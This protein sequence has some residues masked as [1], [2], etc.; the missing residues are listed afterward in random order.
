MNLHVLHFKE[1][2]IK[3]KEGREDDD[4]VSSQGLYKNAV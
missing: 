1:E 4:M 3:Y 2:E